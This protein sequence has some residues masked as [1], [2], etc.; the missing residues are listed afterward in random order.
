MCVIKTR[1]LACS[2]LEAE[3]II[4]CL[5]IREEIKRW[6]SFR[7]WLLLVSFTR[8]T[9]QADMGRVLLAGEEQRNVPVLLFP[10]LP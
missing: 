6:T 2:P 10:G 7:R 8:A 1:Q 5:E 9:Q 3:E 4:T